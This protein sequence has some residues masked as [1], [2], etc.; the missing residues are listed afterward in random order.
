MNFIS[1]IS[2]STAPEPSRSS[3]GGEEEGATAVVEGTSYFLHRI[4]EGSRGEAIVF[5][6]GGLGVNCVIVVASSSTIPEHSPQQTVPSDS[7]GSLTGEPG[8]AENL[9]SKVLSLFAAA[10]AVDFEDGIHTD[11]SRALVRLIEQLGNSAVEVVA[12]IILREKANPAVS[13]EALKWISHIDQPKSYA[14]RLWLLEK[15]LQSPLTI[16]RD[17]ALLGVASLDDQHSIPAINDAIS[18]EACPE[19]REDLIQVLKQLDPQ[20]HLY[21]ER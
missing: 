8:V 18:R 16:V 21:S 15:S 20:C 10:R 13:A 4:P 5:R 1:N 14:F 3:E 6:R 19:L 9:Y 11:F 7:G 2:A 12:S 17:A